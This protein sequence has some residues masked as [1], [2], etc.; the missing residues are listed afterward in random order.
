MFPFRKTHGQPLRLK[1]RAALSL[2]VARQ[3][4]GS[5]GAPP[6]GVLLPAVR[7]LAIFALGSATLSFSGEWKAQRVK[8]VMS[9][10]VYRPDPGGSAD[11]APL[12]T[13]PVSRQA[14]AVELQWFWNREVQQCRA[15][16][17]PWRAAALEEA[18]L[19]S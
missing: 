14:T 12:D 5:R 17:C 13:T 19:N 4:R 9:D 11:R 18:D 6:S 10:T 2:G 7:C 1:V 8:V 3:D 16:L 15:Q